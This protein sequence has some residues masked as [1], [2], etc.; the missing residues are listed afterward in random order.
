ML[1]F[2][3]LRTDAPI[4]QPFATLDVTEADLSLSPE[5]FAKRYLAPMWAAVLSK[6]NDL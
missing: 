6:R 4:N 3:Q 1:V 2:M 5:D